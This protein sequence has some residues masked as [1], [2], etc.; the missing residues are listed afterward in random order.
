MF[1]YYRRHAWLFQVA[2]V[3]YLVPCSYNRKTDQFEQTVYNKLAFAVG[4]MLTV[5]FWYLDQRLMV[6]FYLQNISHIMMIVGCI[7]I[8]VYVS[9]VSSTLLNTFGQ[10][11]RY[12]R[13]M[14]VLFRSDWLLDQYEGVE[15]EYDHRRKFVITMGVLVGMVCTNLLYHR[16]ANI[17]LLSV[18]VA[19]KIF[20]VC[21]LTFVH[22]ICVGAIGV[23][24]EQL[25]VLL[26]L[27]RVRRHALERT[28]QCFIER[29][30]LYAA[31]LRQIDRCFSFPLTLIILLVLI[32]MVYL[33]FD[34]YTILH[35]GRPTIMESNQV[36][37]AE[38]ILRQMWQAI[39]VAVV[40]LT[41][42][43]CQNTSDQLEDTARLVYHYDDDQNRRSRAAKQI[44][45]FLLHNLKRKKQFWASG[46]FAIDYAMLHM[47]FSSIFTYMVILIQ[48]DQLVPERI[49][50]A[51][52]FNTTVISGTNQFHTETR[53]DLVTFLI[54]IFVTGT[55]TCIQW[56]QAWH[57]ESYF[58]S[59]TSYALYLQHI[60][61]FPVIIMYIETFVYVRRTRITGFFNDLFADRS[62]Q[63]H[64]DSWSE[65]SC[66]LGKLI[67]IATIG[68]GLYM[69][70]VALGANAFIT[71][72]RLAHAMLE[73]FRVYVV[74][75]AI[76]L[77]VTCV[78][79]VRMRF[80]HLQTMVQQ[81]GAPVNNVRQWS[82]LL[83]QYQT[84]V[85]LV[86]D[87][88]RYFATS[89]L[90]LLL[91][92]QLQLSNQFFVLFCCV[93]FG[94]NS[95]DDAV[96]VLLTQLW[97]GLFLAVLIV[98]GYACESCHQQIDDTNAA[99][100]NNM[101]LFRGDNAFEQ[102]NREAWKRVD[103]FLLNILC[104]ASRQRFSVAKLFV[105]DNRYVCMV[106]TSTITY[107]AI[108]IQ[109]KQYE[110]DLN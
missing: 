34:F 105:L 109:F 87:I 32:E 49:S 58:T 68:G 39:Y 45:R 95:H 74:W 9:I 81:F 94:T 20:G 67:T 11:K 44:H 8:A 24:M 18:S 52:Y 16:D 35:L 57:G 47:V 65:L 98:V 5:P 10:R 37:Q 63:L 91:Q 31:Q 23:R 4:I 29:F 48:F 1:T 73:A 7:E 55:Y 14:N 82:I 79:V 42:T 28:V 30:E 36:D 43:G 40:L 17:R 99:I 25:K 92:V 83:E 108:L 62:W 72:Y 66:R 12:T 59:H 70:V 22:R 77:Y 89:M 76:I 41:V 75:T 54:N 53:F 50:Y 15:V 56:Y 101:Q 96:M 69:C 60:L 110:L 61:T 106:L 90:M 51:S 85:R 46:F 88:N 21:Y 71:E 104:Q 102:S 6:A 103:Q 93:E 84:G 38:W 78:L 107:L 64:D 19:M 97:E 13:L 2:S 26:E 100:R 86:E 80:K 3:I 27:N 33:M